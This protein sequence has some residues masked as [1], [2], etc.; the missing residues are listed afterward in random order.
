MQNTVDQAAAPHEARPL[1][2]LA[3]ADE[4]ARME[5]ARS[6]RQLP[7]TLRAL[8]E[9]AAVLVPCRPVLGAS[10][11]SMRQEPDWLSRGPVRA[12]SPPGA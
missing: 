2:E 10:R 6:G 11:Y 7:S 8:C 4:A 9:Q 1:T 3:L 12:G 5:R